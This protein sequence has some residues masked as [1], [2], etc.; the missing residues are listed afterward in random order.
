MIK[1]TLIIL[2]ALGLAGIFFFL[3][4]GR[5]SRSGK[6]PGLV[7]G[8]LAPCPATP[9]CVSS[10]DPP[11]PGQAIEP[12]TFDARVVTPTEAWSKLRES[13]DQMAGVR[14]IE[15]TDSYLSA[16]CR[17]GLIG[18]VDDLELHL[19]PDDSTIAVRS[20]SRVGHSDLGA[21]RQRVEKLRHLFNAAVSR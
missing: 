20:A 8:K 14:V 17:S 21:N 11:Q 4:L 19:R 5:V 6:A 18:F 3:Y 7:A 15:F 10:D 16:E 1:T 13:V 12:L 9:N 2:F